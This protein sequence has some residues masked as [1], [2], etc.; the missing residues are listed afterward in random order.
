MSSTSITRRPAHREATGIPSHLRL[1]L[2]LL[3]VLAFI[4]AAVGPQAH[5]LALTARTTYVTA[6]WWALGTNQWPDGGQTLAAHV[7]HESK[8][9]DVDFVKAEAA[10]L[11]CGYTIQGDLYANDKTTKK[12]L[13]GGK[14]YGPSNPTESWPGGE[15]RAEY[16]TVFYTG[17]CV[18]PADDRETRSIESVDCLTETVTSTEEARTRSYTF[19]GNVPVAGEWSSWA[20]TGET[21][22]RSASIADLDG[23]NCATPE[24]PA[25]II[26]TTT[27]ST[28]SCVTAIVTTTTNVT[29][30][31][32]VLVDRK[33]VALDP[34]TVTTSTT[35]PATVAELDAAECPVIDKPEDLVTFGE[36]TSEAFGCGDTT[37][38]QTREHILTPH[39]LVD[40]VWTPD[41]GNAVVTT[42]TRTVALTATQ[43]A[44]IICAST[45]TP[46]SLVTTGADV[47]IPI[48]FAA[49]AAVLGAA[50][51][52]LAARRR[53]AAG[54]T[55]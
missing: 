46:A 52:I 13:A 50:L 51:I 19:A 28:T 22:S 42:E 41:A 34:V 54:T 49:A 27:S 5:A 4:A 32:H 38:D 14:L 11:G 29:T 35:R 25:D 15:Y 24:I 12:L 10:K 16:S 1:P 44:G 31:R 9:L 55:V 7:T 20:P 43:I 47:A 53:S 30:T 40:R 17:D 36:W 26:V 33:I 37:V 18:L 48:S 21:S 6:V 23:A 3:I 39:V 45:D 8:G 2:V